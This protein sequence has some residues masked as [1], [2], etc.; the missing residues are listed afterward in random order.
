[1]ADVPRTKLQPRPV[2]LVHKLRVA[3]TAG[4][5]A[6]ATCAPDDGSRLAIGTAEDNALVVRDPAVSRYHLELQRTSAGVEV[7]DLGSRNGTWVGNVRIE[8]ALVPAGTQ[9]RLGD[10]TLVVEDAG[11]SVA[12]PP[13]D[14]PTSDNLVGDSDAIREVARLVH[15]VARVDSSVLI[16]GETGT[17]KEV[18]ARAIHEASPRRDRELVIVDCGSMPASLI[19]SILF[20]HEKGAFTGA[21][22]RRA[23]AFERAE[24]GTVL[25]DEIGELPLDVQPALLGV[26][27]R[28]A[29][30]RVGGAQSVSVDVRVLAATHRDLR[31]E[32]NAGRFRADLYYR[33]AVAKIVIPPLRERPEDIA[34]LVA[35]FVQRLTG[36]A[37][38]GPLA[39]ALDA[40][41]AHPW[42]GNVRELRNVVEAALVMGELDLGGASTAL[43][44]PPVAGDLPSY[45]DARA[46]ALAR[47]EADY[48]KMLIERAGG[49][50]SEAA[51]L[52]RM[53]RP[54]LLTLLRKHGLRS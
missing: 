46:G 52:A 47:F 16:Q 11:S 51:R 49:N 32:V 50:A 29:F 31:A 13:G 33:L 48:L 24:G 20:G 22:Q 14:V 44:R 5:D 12:P 1:M 45:R 15:R 39:P 6:G 40:L 4:P 35:H 42:S 36:V 30:T 37:E 18:V 25:L 38:L 8:R 3:V 34:P 10:T 27:E 41:R 2:R 17:G 43:P 23:G 26:L 19:A 7:V 21:D 9:L 53:D 54:Y 28:R